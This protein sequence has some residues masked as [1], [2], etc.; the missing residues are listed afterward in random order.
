MVVPVKHTKNSCPTE[1]KE[2]M[3]NALTTISL[4]YAS[5][6]IGLPLKIE[7][8]QGAHFLTISQ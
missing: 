7:G 8:A 5:I 2:A 4:L 6:G 3:W 1:V